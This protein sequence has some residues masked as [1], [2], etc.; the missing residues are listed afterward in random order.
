MRGDLIMV[1]GQK[2]ISFDNL[3]TFKT[4]YDS[5]IEDKLSKKV[6]A[7]EGKDLS[8]NDFTN[9]YKTAISNAVQTIKIKNSSDAVTKTDTEVVIDLSDFYTKSE[10][11]AVFRYKGNKQ[12]LAELNEIPV[13]EREVGDVWNII[14]ADNDTKLNA[15]DNVVWNGTEWDVLAGTLDLA[16]Y[17]K[18]EEGKSLVDDTEISRLA[19]IEDKAQENKIEVIQ[20]NGVEVIPVDKIVNLDF[21][22]TI[23]EKINN[24]YVFATD[25]DIMSLFV[26]EFD[27]GLYTKMAT[28]YFSGYNSLFGALNDLTGESFRDD[29]NT[30]GSSSQIEDLQNIPTNKVIVPQNNAEMHQAINSSEW[31]LE[32]YIILRQNN[33]YEDIIFAM[34]NWD[35]GKGRFFCAIANPDVANKNIYNFGMLTSIKKDYAYR[36]IINDSDTFEIDNVNINTVHHFAICKY[37]NKL[38]LYIDGNF[39]KSIDATEFPNP[40]RLFFAP[41]I[42]DVLFTPFAKYKET[43]TPV[44]STFVEEFT[45]NNTLL[46]V[47][48]L[49][50]IYGATDNITGTITKLPQKTIKLT[51]ICG[52]LRFGGLKNI[53]ELPMIDYNGC[54]LTDF[55]MNHCS[56]VKE[57]PFDIDLSGFDPQKSLKYTFY[58]CTSLSGEVRFINVPSSF[59]SQL[60]RSTLGDFGTYTIKIVNTI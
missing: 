40:C 49:Y 37:D 38:N 16:D 26:P 12:T 10:I 7:V 51:K 6:T 53:E 15:G 41:Q 35:S 1:D 39:I 8:T 46:L 45:T 17:L 14:E 48:D 55:S 60:N 25:D 9:E 59:V 47:A 31:T 4:Q 3:K 11:S 19:E 34:E 54:Q 44:K 33:D 43:F 2:H 56:K 28:Q 57:I 27:N 23:D 21:N 20:V 22:S 29:G 5:I 13:G 30:S 32:F 42:V 50:K 36:Y 52:D 24:A 18:K 58:N